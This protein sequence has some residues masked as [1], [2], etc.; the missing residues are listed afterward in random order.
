V[1][2]PAD[3]IIGA[4]RVQLHATVDRICDRFAIIADLKAAPD[5]ETVD[6][7]TRAPKSTQSG[8]FYLHVDPTGGAAFSRPTLWL[9]D[10]AKAVKLLGRL[11]IEAQRLADTPTDAATYCPVCTLSL[12]GCQVKRHGANGYHRGACYQKAYR[13]GF[14]SA[15][16]E[17]IAQRVD[18][19]NLGVGIR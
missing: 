19:G 14:K 3:A 16:W 5:R 13:A 15:R 6:C 10:V 7:E 1:T 18:R 4:I 17:T 2:R 8:T 12:A 11:D 9:E